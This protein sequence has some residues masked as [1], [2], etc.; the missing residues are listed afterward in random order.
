PAREA[1]RFVFFTDVHTR[2][3]W[4]T[5]LALEMAAK[6]IYAQAAD[7]VIGGGD[8]ITDGF[9]SLAETVAPR[10]DAFMEMWNSLRGPKE[11]AIGNHDLVAA[12]PAD[13]SPASPDPR[14]IFREKLGVPRTYRSFE[15]GGCHLVLLDGIQ[16]TDTERNYRGFIEPAQ[17]DWLRGDLEGVA[18]ET[19]VILITHIPLLTAF[20]QVTQGATEPAPDHRVMVNNRDVLK[21]F[22]RHNLLLVL[23]GHLHVDE[24]LRW[25]RTTFITGGAVSGAWWRG[26][27]RGTDAGFGVVT[28]RNGRVEWEYINYGWIPRRPADA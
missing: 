12:R 22:E 1:F 8:L 7:L 20:Y 26:P 4:E 27:R 14:A 13:G 2:V 19:P 3:E 10:W 11:T 17:L 21:L 9:D 24:M 28:L 25:R 5:P 15:A 6:A 18:P 23:Q 16:V